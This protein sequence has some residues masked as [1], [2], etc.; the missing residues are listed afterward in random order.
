M[1]WLLLCQLIPLRVNR[2]AVQ[3]ALSL[4]LFTDEQINFHRE[5][6]PQKNTLA[7][8]SEYEVVFIW[9]S[10]YRP[11]CLS[12]VMSKTDKTSDE[13]NHRGSLIEE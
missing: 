12:F 3:T 9:A 5:E 7:F 13:S 6:S 11:R 10:P 1:Q 4:G 8:I 2:T